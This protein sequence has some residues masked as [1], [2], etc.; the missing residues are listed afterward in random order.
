MYMCT[1]SHTYKYMYFCN[2][3]YMFTYI[4]SCKAKSSFNVLC[5]SEWN[6]LWYTKTLAFLKTN[7]II[8]M[9]HLTNKIMIQEKKQTNKLQLYIYM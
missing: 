9:D 8:N 1:C 6:S 5:H 3:Q 4:Y 7:I 2:V